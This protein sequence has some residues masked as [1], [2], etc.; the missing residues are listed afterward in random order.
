MNESRKIRDP[1][2]D[3]FSE[4]AGAAIE[5]ALDDIEIPWPRLS[6]LSEV[7]G[8]VVPRPVLKEALQ[9]AEG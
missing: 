1:Q 6:F 8:R 4:A 3:A 2:F 5:A 7:L 9:V